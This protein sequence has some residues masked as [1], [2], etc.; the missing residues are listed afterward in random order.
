M[1][2]TRTGTYSPSDVSVVISQASSGLVWVV[3]GYAEDSFIN[4]ERDSDTYD[5]YTGVD[6]TATRIYK[7]NTSAK[8]TVMLGQSSATNDILSQLYLNDKATRNSTGLF[9]LTI[10]DG[11]GR[12]VAFAHE[13][14]IGKVP[15]SPYGSGMGTRDWVFHCTALDDFIGGNSLVS[16]EAVAAMDKLG[17]TIS[18]DWIAS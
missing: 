1:S 11:S 14:Y 2:N 3:D 7:A 8:V 16:P 10:K 4:I 12:S 17:G 9:S 13:A 18:T 15:N 5:H 6:N